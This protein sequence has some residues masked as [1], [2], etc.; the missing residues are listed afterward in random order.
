MLFSF[1][2]FPFLG[3]EELKSLTDVS[4][5]YRGLLFVIAFV[6]IG[7]ESDFRELKSYMKGGKPFILYIVG[8]SFNLV[9]TLL[10]A[11]LVFSNVS[12]AG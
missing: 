8:Q 10:V 3:E 1:I 11:L 9:L 2:L 4:K 7:L 5:S 6:S 12:Y